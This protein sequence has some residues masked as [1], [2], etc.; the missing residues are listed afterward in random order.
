MRALKG[1]LGDRPIARMEL[2]FLS[3]TSPEPAMSI[4]ILVDAFDRGGT[5]AVG[6]VWILLIVPAGVLAPVVYPARRPLPEGTRRGVV[7]GMAAAARRRS[8]KGAQAA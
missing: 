2:A 8:P 6:F 3:S 4:A 7:Y 5:Q 1:V